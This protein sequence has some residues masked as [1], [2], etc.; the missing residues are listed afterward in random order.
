[1]RLVLVATAVLLLCALGVAP[2]ATA[3][4][5]PALGPTPTA[6]A[7]EEALRRGDFAAAA[8]F[9]AEAARLGRAAGDAELELQALLQLSDAQQALGNY[10]DALT[11]LTR[12]R[13]LAEASGDA[14]RLASARGALGN[15]Y[16]ALDAPEEAGRELRAAGQ[17]AEKAEAWSLAASIRNNLGNHYAIQRGRARTA[18]A[19]EQAA[20]EADRAYASAVR[21]A[22]RAGDGTLAARALANW[23]RLAV[24]RGD[25]AGALGLLARALERAE[26][27]PSSHTTVYTLLHVGRSYQLLDAGAASP[28]RGLL[29]SA[30][31]SLGRAA[32]MAD[33]LGDARGSAWAQ[34]YLGG[35]YE[36]TGRLEE[37]LASTRRALFAAQQAGAAD[38]QVLWHAQ[39]ARLAARL[40]HE[41]EAAAEYQA[42]VELLATLRPAMTVSYGD[43]AGSFREGAGQ[44]YFEYVDLLLRRAARQADATRAQADLA[45]AQ[46]VMEQVKAAELRDYFRDDCV[47]AYR[48][49]IQT[50]ETASRSAA[51]VYPVSLEDRLEI[52]VSGPEGIRQF[53]VPVGAAELVE[54]V[55]V[56]RRLLEKR[57]TRQYL[58]HAQKVHE[59]LIAPFEGELAGLGVDTLVFVPGGALRTVPMAA[60]HD[61]E[62]FLVERYPVATT[63][64]LELT[65]PRPLDRERVQLFLGGLSESVQG[66]PPLQHVPEELGSIRS[67][68]GGELLLDEKFAV[69]NVEERMLNQPYSIVHIASHGEFGGEA[70][71]TYLLAHDGRIS[72]D[73][74]SSYVGATR[75]RKQPLELITL[76]ACETAAGDDRTALG[77]AGLAI[78]AGA[79][80]ALGTLWKV[81][82]LAASNLIV[83]FYRELQDPQV[84]RAEA[85]R[86]AQR[87]MLEDPRYRHPGYWAAFLLI[88]NWL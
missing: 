83:V 64:G 2:R 19:A 9:F 5:T 45:L 21:L 11:S 38:A 65:D 76:S 37:A 3:A 23:G 26:A 39:A 59:W 28:E 72:M 67:L 56:L 82:D 14:R 66:Y 50:L 48:E 36:R 49:K 7:G 78:K 53:T 57:T 75:F 46:Q 85:L 27:L 58:P 25:G 47:D 35:L 10:D 13:D 69:G 44:V 77:L 15:L 20:A 79:R 81:N 29:R 63:P 73:Q 16:I 74:L 52:L 24:E 12:A 1:M 8:G 86:R 17:L 34:G 68:Y 40:G 41:E 33:G 43:P 6:V 31:R 51:I 88:S 84:S 54:E 80:S 30:H 61:G 22:D 62:R 55:R 42:A 87:H 32:S 60:L 70:S 4:D 18:D 71:D